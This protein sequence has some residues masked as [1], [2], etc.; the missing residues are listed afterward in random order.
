M[1]ID[2]LILIS[3]DDHVV[4]PPD[5]FER[6]LPGHVARHRAARGAPRRRH[7]RVGVRRQR[8]PEH[9]AQRGRRPAA[10]RV[11]H[12]A[13]VV[14][15][16]PL[17]LLRHRRPGARHGRQRRAR[18]DVLPVVPEPVR[19]AVQPLHRQGRRRSRSCRPTT[20]GTSTSGAAA[21]PGRFI[22]LALPP[23]WDPEPMADEV[24]RV[25]AK[26][27]HAVSF[28]ENPSQAEAAE[29]SQRP[30]GPVLAG[31]RRTRARSCACTSAR[32][33]ASSSPRATRRSTC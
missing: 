14:R 13:D 27:C 26:G 18:L 22:P 28:S 8:D 9:R 17:R 6:H 19:A 3:V 30:L 33:R 23:I 21:R 31:V 16:D 29:L 2:D 25:A 11:R 12:G 32:R 15:G 10:R 7:R 1:Q 5:M 24:R 20:T 4:E